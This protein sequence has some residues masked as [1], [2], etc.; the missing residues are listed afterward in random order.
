[1]PETAAPRD[2]FAS[3]HLFSVRLVS[4][5]VTLTLVLVA[6]SFTGLYPSSRSFDQTLSV[7][8]RI[9]IL[10]CGLGAVVVRRTR[11]NRMRL[12]DTAAL[13]G[14]SGLLG[15]LQKTTLLVTALAVLMAIMGFLITTQTGNPIDTLL[16]AI[17]ALAILLFTYP[18][19]A[20]WQR[21]LQTATE[22]EGDAT[23]PTKGSAS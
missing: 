14:S 2:E 16:P 7:A 8:L 1:M 23:S 13:R 4:A 10:F 19:R 5:A 15:S 22:P 12:R 21:T 6:L 9:A 20:A 18:R 17:A 11:F 3:R